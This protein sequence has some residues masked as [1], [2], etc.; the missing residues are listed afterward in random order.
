MRAAGSWPGSNTGGCWRSRPRS[1]IAHGPVRPPRL[2]T[3][4]SPGTLGY[5]RAPRSP[6]PPERSK[7][8]SEER[9]APRVAAP[10]GLRLTPQHVASDPLATC[11]VPSRPRQTSRVNEPAR[12]DVDDPELPM[13]VQPF[14]GRSDHTPPRAA[15][16]RAAAMGD[17]SPPVSLTRE[18]LNARYRKHGADDPD[19]SV[20]IPT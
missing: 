10:Q 7:T 3:G 19:G 13:T 16:H 2:A 17:F 9:L 14:A 4:R 1:A 11:H 6:G 8:V 15:N 20:L 12:T 18:R 5:L